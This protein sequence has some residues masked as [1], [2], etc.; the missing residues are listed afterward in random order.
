MISTDLLL[1]A[2]FITPLGG[3][4]GHSDPF[5]GFLIELSLQVI[6]YGIAIATAVYILK[7]YRPLMSKC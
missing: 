5:I 2:Q 1:I 6:I 3:G 7:N 4:G